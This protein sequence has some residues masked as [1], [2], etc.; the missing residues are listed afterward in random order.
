MHND[1][2]ITFK[3]DLFQSLK[4]VIH[5]LTLIILYHSMRC[6][7]DDLKVIAI[8]ILFILQFKN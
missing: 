3:C 5:F 8:V 7:L 2:K 6:E 4:I 1:T